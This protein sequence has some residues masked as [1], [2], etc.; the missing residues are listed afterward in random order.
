MSKVDGPESRVAVGSREPV[1]A[2]WR[3][4]FGRDSSHSRDV[5]YYCE[6]T[7]VYAWAKSRYADYARYAGTGESKVSE[8]SLVPPPVHALAA[9]SS[10]PTGNE[11]TG[12]NGTFVETSVHMQRSGRGATIWEAF[13]LCQPSRSPHTML[14]IRQNVR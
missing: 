2:R 12:R 1:Y 14:H 6:R 8:R 10:D 7:C 13:L 5:N 11:R 9:R 4:F 3:A